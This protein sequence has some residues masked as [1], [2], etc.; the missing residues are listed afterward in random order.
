M[1]ELIEEYERYEPLIGLLSTA[2]GRWEN[3]AVEFVDF[4]RNVTALER[5]GG[6]ADTDGSVPPENP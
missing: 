3:E 6:L 4:N 5:C 2:I 1:D